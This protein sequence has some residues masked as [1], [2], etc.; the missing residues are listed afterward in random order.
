ML[1][2]TLAEKLSASSITNFTN[3]VYYTP[4][5][6][7]QMHDFNKDDYYDLFAYWGSGIQFEETNYP[8]GTI[9][10]MLGPSCFT[11]SNHW[12]GSMLPR[13]PS[14]LRTD[15]DKYFHGFGANFTNLPAASLGKIAGYTSVSASTFFASNNN[16]F[17]SCWIQIESNIVVRVDIES[18]SKAS[19]DAAIDSLKTLKISKEKIL[20]IVKAS[21]H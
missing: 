4:P 9:L 8:Y 21:G 16:C 1:V 19:V 7:F 12:A 14:D 11:Y 3:S 6:G 5:T 17:Y 15:F 20:E 10:F 2:L 18:I 13:N